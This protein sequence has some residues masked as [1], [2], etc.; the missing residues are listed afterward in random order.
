MR[1]LTVIL[2]AA[3][4]GGLAWWVS[5]HPSHPDFAMFWGG[6]NTAHPYDPAALRQT[7]G[8]PPGS[9]VVFINPPSALPIF[10][11]FGLLGLRAALVL[12]AALSGAALALSSRSRWAPLILFTPP[13][14][15]ALPGGQ[16][17]VLL[18]SLLFGGLQLMAWPALAGALFGIALCLK[19]QFVILILFALLIQRQWK[20]LLAALL[21]FALIT[22]L[23][24]LL[25]GPAQ[26]IE[27]LRSLP[28]F[29]ALHETNP[30]LRRN[31]IAFG[32]PV[33]IRVTALAAG[34]FL[35]VRGLYEPAEAFVFSICSALI[36][37]NHA[38][39]YEFAMLGPAYACL[40][41]RRGWGAPAAILFI[42]T[43]AFIWASPGLLH[44]QPRLVAVA[45]LILAVF[46]DSVS[47]KPDVTQ[48]MPRPMSWSRCR[49]S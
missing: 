19:P 41:A 26:W 17:S 37:S 20:A 40:I 42:L 11:L 34:A 18:G 1:Y 9:T 43:P 7:L 36:V 2:T 14:L 39:G 46:A 25:F 6:A 38:M 22:T 24:A 8:W 10:A 29:L 15:W 49:P 13:V 4:A 30:S 47:P 5:L 23:S 12:W 21:I 44:Y 35:T 28:K 27:W 45:M 33:A 48:S 3:L 31:E 16:T 32:L